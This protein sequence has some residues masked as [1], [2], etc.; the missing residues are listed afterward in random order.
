MIDQPLYVSEPDWET[1]PIGTI[2]LSL[3][4]IDRAIQ[5]SQS[6]SNPD[7][8]PDKQWQTYINAL[9]LAGFKEWLDAWAA[10]LHLDE[11]QS[12]LQFLQS[13]NWVDAVC[14]LQ[15]G[16]FRLCL[17][18]VPSLS[19][20]V[21][22]LD[23]AIVD[24]PALLPHFYV[25]VQVIEEE[26]LVQIY[27][28][29]QADQIARQRHLSPLRATDRTY[30]VPLNWFTPDPNQLLLNLRCLEADAI[31]LPVETVVTEAVLT[32]VAEDSTS[33]ASLPNVTQQ[34]V[35]VGI[36]L[37]DQLDSIAEE[38][39]WMLMPAFAPATAGLRS[40]VGEL[41]TIAE[42]LDRLGISI[43]VQARAAYRD[44]A[45]GS[46]AIR[47]YAVVWELLSTDTDPEWA[48]LLI[49]GTP[50]GQYL[51]IGIRLQVHDA[52]QLLVEET[53]TTEQ[54]YLYTQVAATWNEQFQ[55]SIGF[56]QQTIE[57]VSFAFN[58]DTDTN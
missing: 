53:A 24:S 7:T 57:T 19:D 49:L 20:P 27:G 25:V 13:T 6:I 1:L 10:D 17:V 2:E 51:P 23:K 36:W 22:M 18:A 14:N 8:H 56:N 54:P 9:A 30:C 39:S 40:T 55:V 3:E 44:I 50:T 31:T 41:E 16:D 21:V 12:T 58:P 26:M 37:R 29:L 43:P 5:V 38:L 46:I 33:R 48:L 28:Y 11:S 32:E 35:N 45:Q 4:Q 47:L 52:E 42:A 34:A 15:I